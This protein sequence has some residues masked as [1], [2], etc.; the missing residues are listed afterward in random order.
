MDK[1]Q[2]S[3]LLEGRLIFFQQPLFAANFNSRPYS[4]GD[5]DNRAVVT[6]TSVFQLTPLHEGRL[7]LAN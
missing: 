2:L 5:G 3:P 7:T 4:R 6:D 1:F